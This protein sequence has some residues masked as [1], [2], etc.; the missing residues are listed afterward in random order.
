M[1]VFLTGGT[2][3]I[4][5]AVIAELRQAGHDVTG[6]ARTDAAAGALALAGAS[7][8]RG[9]LEDLD[10][11]RA[12][13]DGSEGVIHLGYVHDFS[14]FEDN[15]HIDRAAIQ[16]MGEVLAGSDR[17]LVIAHGTPVAAGRV[18]TEQDSADLSVAGGRALSEQLLLRLVERGVR[19]A[20]VR[21]P[22]T[23]H[24]EGDHGFAPIII[25]IAR[26]KGMSAY[27]D[28]GSTR[29]PAVHRDDAAT[30]FRLAFEN[31]GAGT[32][33]HAVADEGVAIRDIA[34]VIGAKLDL[35]VVSIPPE[36]AREHFGFLSGFIGVD[37]PASSVQT[38]KQTGW[39]PWRPGLIADLAAGYYFQVA[40]PAAT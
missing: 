20:S 26:E 28:D 12:G 24:G 1:N 38:Q 32:V 40:Q 15:A 27:I 8:L 21:L 2:G 34:E 11:L 18:A 39:H 36:Q 7:V 30:L 6:L 37:A 14:R 22:R 17:P 23:V 35:P 25:R 10:S 13:A 31:A 3:F 4:G 5:T 33:L 9:S 19:A 29:W 16:A